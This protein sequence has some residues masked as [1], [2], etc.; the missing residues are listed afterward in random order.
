MTKLKWH[1]DLPVDI[2]EADRIVRNDIEQS[3]WG[4]EK[5]SELIFHTVFMGDGD[6]INNEPIVLVWGEPGDDEQFHCQYH[7]DAEWTTFD[8]D[9]NQVDI[10]DD[11]S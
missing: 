2:L 1:G 6:D 4:L 8:E 3:L 10:E 11:M 7:P 9:E 5:P